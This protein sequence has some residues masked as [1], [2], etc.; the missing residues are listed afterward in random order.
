MLPLVCLVFQTNLPDLLSVVCFFLRVACQ[1]KKSL[2]NFPFSALCIFTFNFSHTIRESIHTHTGTNPLKFINRT[3]LFF[4]HQ[5]HFYPLQTLLSTYK[6]QSR[7]WNVL[8]EKFVHAA[9]FPCGRFWCWSPRTTP[10]FNLSFFRP[11]DEIHFFSVFSRTGSNTHRTVLSQ[12][13]RRNT[14]RN[15]FSTV[16]ASQTNHFLSTKK[17]SSSIITKILLTKSTMLFQMRKSAQRITLMQR[18]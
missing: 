2:S 18:T 9:K 17:Q 7:P 6:I 15:R 3:G 16:R 1:K 14:V 12:F 10:N 4:Q 5:R 13:S 11:R 8:S